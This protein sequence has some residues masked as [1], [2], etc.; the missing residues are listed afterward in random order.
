[1]QLFDSTRIFSNQAVQQDNPSRYPC[2][3]KVYEA[4]SICLPKADDIYVSDDGKEARVN[5]QHLLDHQMRRL[6]TKDYVDQFVKIKAKD[7]SVRF[8]LYFKYG[9]DGSS[10]HSQYQF[11][12]QSIFLTLFF[13]PK[14]RVAQISS[15]M[16]FIFLFKCVLECIP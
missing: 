7:P 8:V 6:L 1:M 9:A 4:K 5:I 16:E 12:G 13:S 15:K 2:Y 11:R 14:I 10:S 3:D